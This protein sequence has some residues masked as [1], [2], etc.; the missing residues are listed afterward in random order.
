MKGYLNH[1]H[2]PSIQDSFTQS[3]IRPARILG[4]VPGIVLAS[5]ASFGHPN[6]KK[7]PLTPNVFKHMIDF[8][9][10]N[11]LPMTLYKDMTYLKK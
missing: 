8:L 1:W 6:P 2:Y 9:R 10:L 4:C 11:I 7:S 5:R 3:Y